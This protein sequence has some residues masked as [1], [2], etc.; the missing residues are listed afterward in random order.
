MWSKSYSIDEEGEEGK[1]FKGTYSTLSALFYRGDFYLC[2]KGWF[3]ARRNNDQSVKGM[4]VVF[5]W[6]NLTKSMQGQKIIHRILD[7]IFNLIAMEQK[8]SI[9]YDNF[10]TQNLIKAVKFYPK[11]KV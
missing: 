10:D 1:E 6:K 9:C 4:N 8:I 11:K 7:R 5:S 3:I 2:Y